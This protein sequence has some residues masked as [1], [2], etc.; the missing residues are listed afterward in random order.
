MASFRRDAP[1]QVIITTSLVLILVV[2]CRS[3][4][5]ISSTTS[6]SLGC[7][8]EPG[9]VALQNVEKQHRQDSLNLLL[10]LVL[11]V[12]T[13]LTTWLFKHHRF[14]FM[15]ETG[16]AMIYGVIVGVIVFYVSSGNGEDSYVAVEKGKCGSGIAPMDLYLHL[17]YDELGSQNVTFLYIR[18]SVVGQVQ[19]KSRDFGSKLQFDPEIFFNI[20]LPPIIFYAGYS[21]KRRHFFRNLGSILTYAFAGTL[22]S[23]LV[24]GG[25]MYLF[26][27]VIMRESRFTSQ[28]CFLFGALISAT[29]P[30]TVLAVFHDL[31][32]DVDMYILVFGES[33][34]NDAVAIVLTRTVEEFSDTAFTAGGFFKSVGLFAGI[35]MGSFAMG[36]VMG[37]ITAI[38]TKFTRI[39]DFPLLETAMF[40]I[41]SYSCY[42]MAEAAQLTGIVAVLF[43]GVTQ[44]HYTYNN[45]SEESKRRTKEAFELLNFLA[46]NFIFSYMGLSVFNHTNKQFSISF[47]LA[48][49]LGIILG[50]LLNIYPLSFLL[51]LGRKEK[52]PWNVQHMLFFSGL[53]GAIAFALAIRNNAT[54]GQELILSTTL[55]IVLV[56]V[57]VC[58]GLTTQMLAWLKIRVGVTEDDTNQ[59][60]FHAGSSTQYSQISDQE[61]RLKRRKQQAWVV[62]KWYDFDYRF[63]KPIFTKKGADLRENVPTCCLPLAECLT[64]QDDNPSV[65]ED[66]D[67]DFIL[68][69]DINPTQVDANSP[70]NGSATPPGPRPPEEDATLEGDLGLGDH[71]LHTAGILST[72]GPAPTRV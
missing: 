47:T 10:F 65:T 15:H 30:V 34:L 23:F 3:Q 49:F 39:R 55:L 22:I 41:M 12:V 16:L 59:N 50:R 45:L 27:I 26:V 69:D 6:T 31:H 36:A 61:S 4:T 9:K 21:L 32:V 14:R 17:V 11:L 43:C 44:A 25:I 18:D 24:V 20:L 62:R 35:F 1:A 7:E 51:N 58:G 72:G 56:T 29:D 63:L 19:E 46:E 38:I 48:A 67:D 71:Q 13:I 60:A 42:L 33:V 40:T 57:V 66:S 5:T 70:N 52:I 53:R 54:Y 8:V 37:I 2:C 28:D 68:D 64:V